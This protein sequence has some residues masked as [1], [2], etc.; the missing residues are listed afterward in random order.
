MIG[1]F[2]YYSL[3]YEIA[4]ASEVL[5]LIWRDAL[6]PQGP[7]LLVALS[8]SSFSFSQET[9]SERRDCAIKFSPAFAPTIGEQVES[10]IWLL[11]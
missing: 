8:V 1:S 7:L 9:A 5:G 4:A 11:L 10:L 6:P 3:L 2:I